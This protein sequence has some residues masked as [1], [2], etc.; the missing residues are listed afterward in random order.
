MKKTLTA[1]L[2]CLLF[3]SAVKAQD[4]L[5]N[6][7]FDKLV[8]QDITYSIFGESTPV[9]GIEVDISKPEA[10]LSGIIPLN[11]DKSLLLGLDFKGGITDKSFSLLKG[12]NT[13]NTAFE[14]KLSFYIFLA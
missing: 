14:F 6:K 12:Y 3:G 7:A 4:L 8:I 2:L 11:K 1:L 13:F 9:A 5:S 10:S